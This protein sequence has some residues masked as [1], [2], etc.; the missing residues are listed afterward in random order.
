MNQMEQNFGKYYWI[1][2]LHVQFNTVVLHRLAK[3]TGFHSLTHN[4]WYKREDLSSLW[5]IKHISFYVSLF[6]SLCH[7]LLYVP[8]DRT[9]AI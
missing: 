5:M 2:N 8:R 1:W 4:L 3:K 9:I 7:S 6:L